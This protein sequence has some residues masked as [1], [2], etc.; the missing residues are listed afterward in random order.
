VRWLDRH[1]PGSMRSE[2]PARTNAQA[3]QAR[4]PARRRGLPKGPGVVV[5][6]TVVVVRGLLVGRCWSWFSL[7]LVVAASVPLNCVAHVV[8]WK[9]SRP[10]IPQPPSPA[11]PMSMAVVT[12]HRNCSSECTLYTGV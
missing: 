4:R 3:E 12:S 6:V 5:V 9:I 1:A 11:I 2:S 7:L 8:V 10:P